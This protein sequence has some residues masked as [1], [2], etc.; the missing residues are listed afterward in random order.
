[1]FLKVP[2]IIFIAAIC[3][4]F[5]P[6]LA[7]A[8]D[9]TGEALN[10]LATRNCSFDSDLSGWSTIAGSP[11]HSVD[12]DPTAG[13]A[14]VTGTGELGVSSDCY[15]LPAASQGE[16]VTLGARIKP[17]SGV[18]IDAGCGVSV[19]EY[20]GAGCTGSEETNLVI[21]GGGGSFPAD[22]WTTVSMTPG[23]LNGDTLSMR[24]NVG[25]THNGSSYAVRVDN[26]VMAPATI[27]VEIQSFSID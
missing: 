13:S 24:V 23:S 1:M 16:A 8:Q 20:T 26:I 4:V 27:P 22:T 17:L 18:L 12:G 25:C 6:N 10:L 5:S 2:K 14:E 21:G 7:L 9:C 15:P 3:A 19:T 11:S